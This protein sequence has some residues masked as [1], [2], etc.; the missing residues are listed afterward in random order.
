MAVQVIKNAEHFREF[1][2]S[3]DSPIK[4]KPYL[5]PIESIRWGK[6]RECEVHQLS[7]SLKYVAHAA[8]EHALLVPKFKLF[9]KVSFSKILD[10]PEIR[11]IAKALFCS[12]TTI[13]LK[14]INFDIEIL[15]V[16]LKFFAA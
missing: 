3:G 14:E 12:S 7:H 15:K 6:S 11:I 1:N 13:F 5:S 4:G 10:R 2:I 9:L 8:C 16:N